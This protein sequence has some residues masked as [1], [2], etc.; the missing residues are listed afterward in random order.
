ML[1]LITIKLI[2]TFL[3]EAINCMEITMI[4]IIIIHIKKNILK[5][6]IKKTSL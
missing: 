2:S 4:I 1:N 5:Q 3:Y 6:I